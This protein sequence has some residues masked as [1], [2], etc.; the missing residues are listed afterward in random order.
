MYWARGPPGDAR[1]RVL[2]SIN[3][4]ATSGVSGSKAIVRACRIGSMRR[5][6]GHSVVMEV[7]AASEASQER[8]NGGHGILLFNTS[9]IVQA[10]KPV[11]QAQATPRRLKPLY[12]AQANLRTPSPSQARHHDRMP[13]EPP[14][15]FWW[16]SAKPL[17]STLRCNLNTIFVGIFQIL[18]RSQDGTS[19]L[20]R[21]NGL[22]HVTQ[23]I[24]LK[25]GLR[26][27][28]VR[29]KA[30]ALP[31]DGIRQ[32]GLRKPFLLAA[33]RGR[34]KMESTII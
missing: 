17:M 14:G 15:G 21:R 13:D 16:L 26:P 5:M 25:P 34:N 28:F 10:H 3:G 22:W 23:A 4:Q 12:H 27:T 2:F 20:A 9:H 1:A 31:V 7:T 11:C 29:Q 6:S 32:N 18:I 8:V 33:S 24:L 30:T 19:H